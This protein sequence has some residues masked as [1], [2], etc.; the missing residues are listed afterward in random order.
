MPPVERL[1]VGDNA[2][3]RLRLSRLGVPIEWEEEPFEWVRPHRFSV[4]RRYVRGPIA[5]LRTSAQLEPRTGG[6]THLVY[7]MRVRPRNLAGRV[8]AQAEIGVLRRRRFA[9]VLR[10]YD[11]RNAGNEAVPPNGRPTLAPGGSARIAAAR[12]ALLAAGRSP[13]VVEWLCE[14]VERGDDGSVE[15]MRPYV[16]AEAWGADRRDVLTA[17]LQATRCGLLELRWQL[18]CPLCRGS[19]ATDG[20]LDAVGKTLHCETCRIDFTADFERSV[21][22]T[23]RPTAAVRAVEPLEFCVGGPQLT[24]HIVSQQ[25]VDGSAT[26]TVDVRLEAGRYRFRALDSRSDVELVSEPGG[27]HAATVQLASEGWHPTQLAVGQSCALTL[28][29]AT[30][31]E[32]LFVLERTEWADN[33]ATA[34]EVTVLQLYRDL[35]AREALRAQAPISVGSVT[36]VFTDLR[37]STRFYREIGDA[38]AFGSVLDH[39]ALLR[40]VVGAQDGAVVKQMGDA[41]MAVFAR[42]A[43]AVSAMV[44]GQREVAGKPLALKV[45]IHSGP[46]IA[47][48]QNGVLDYFGSTVNLAARL[49][50]MATGD[51]LVMSETVLD[52]PEVRSLGLRAERL[53][54][55]PKDFEDDVVT[56]W[57]VIPA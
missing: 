22:V 47:V 57:R 54:G 56:L 23:F 18:L 15:R 29:N 16:L 27:P 2:R 25:L 55:V 52:D 7:E 35:F 37:G 19:A 33:A 41:I 28:L 6:G 40:R 14:L 24:P 31:R 43:A 1:G 45:G 20:T 46:C 5:S 12:D 11:A 4:V 9:A 42:P 32:R 8:A 36:I 49:V 48:N 26:R 39:V 21:E 38:P 13:G 53:E 3:R 17:C 30:E 44:D 10:S 50:T 51:D 34:A